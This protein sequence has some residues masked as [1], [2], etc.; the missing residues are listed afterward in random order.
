MLEIKHISKT[1]GNQT[2]LD[3][4]TLTIPDGASLA[5]VGESGSGKSTLARIIMA[6]ERPTAGSLS[7]NGAAA[8]GS[9]VTQAT[10]QA[11]TQ[12][13]TFK[14][15]YRQLQCVFQN[16]AATLDPRMTVLQSIMEPIGRFTTLG[17]KARV[18]LA[19]LYAERIGL[20]LHLMHERPGR[21]S[22][23]QYQ[24]A[25][26][27]KA[28]VVKPKL[29]VCDEMV[30]NL[31]RIHQ[32]QIIRLLQK[33]KAEE[34]L[35]LLFITH[36]LSLVPELCEHIAVLKEGRVVDAF[37]STAL[38]AGAANLHPYTVSLLEAAGLY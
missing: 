20:P 38:G 8:P 27:A 33:L 5:L 12:A 17:K 32:Y 30:S 7:F 21:L 13:A 24:R 1:I 4:I 10:T 15:W 3:D 19:M 23:G 25:C 16:T 14:S 9:R 35:S 31:D 6:L 36:D 34:G 22:G 26:I 11:T 37:D 28:L 2:V 29:L 18:G